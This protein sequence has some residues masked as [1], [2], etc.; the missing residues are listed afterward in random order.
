MKKLLP[1]SIVS[2]IVWN[3]CC[4]ASHYSS[5]SHSNSSLGLT[6]A[7][8]RCMRAASSSDRPAVA[9]PATHIAVD[10]PR[11][12]AAS[13]DLLAAALTPEAPTDRAISSALVVVRRTPP[14]IA[15]LTALAQAD[16][17]MA[18]FFAA[19][20]GMGFS[21]RPAATPEEL[22]AA[23]RTIGRR[24]EI[25][26]APLLTAGA[27]TPAALEADSDALRHR[28]TTASQAP[29]NLRSYDDE[30]NNVQDSNSED[31]PVIVGPEDAL[32][33]LFNLFGNVFSSGLDGLFGCFRQPQS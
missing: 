24:R 14:S 1:L 32:M 18:D 3:S 33:N 4:S 27:S 19:Q 9:L 28:N 5:G 10:M 26:A 20:H 12:T 21:R 25:L 7:E 13:A 15:L 30:I 31:A 22:E 23:M 2:L 6:R 11:E 16:P 17:N 8:E 29:T